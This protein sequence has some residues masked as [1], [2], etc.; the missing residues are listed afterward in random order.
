MAEQHLEK[1]SSEDNDCNN[2]N[3]C[4]W[5]HQEDESERMQY[6]DNFENY[7]QNDSEENNYY[8]KDQVFN[9]AEEDNNDYRLKDPDNY[10]TEDE[11]VEDEEQHASKDDYNNNWDNYFDD[12]IQI[13]PK[14]PRKSSR[15]TS[16]RDYDPKQDIF[17]P[18]IKKKLFDVNSSKNVSPPPRGRMNLRSSGVI[19]D[20]EVL[21]LPTT[22]RRSLPQTQ[23]EKWLLAND[24]NTLPHQSIIHIAQLDRSTYKLDGQRDLEN[25]NLVNNQKI[26]H[27]QEFPEPVMCEECNGNTAEV[28]CKQ[29]N[30]SYCK[31]CSDTKV[32]AHLPVGGANKNK[33]SLNYQED[34][35]I[36]TENEKYVCQEIWSRI[37]P[38]RSI[39]SNR[40]LWECQNQNPSNKT[41]INQNKEANEFWSNLLYSNNT[42]ELD[43]L[44]EYRE[45]ISLA[46]QIQ[47]KIEISKREYNFLELKKGKDSLT[48]ISDKIKE[49]QIVPKSW[50]DQ[51]G[52]YN[53]N[54]EFLP[55]L[56]HHSTLVESDYDKGPN[57][58]V[59]AKHCSYNQKLWPARVI[60]PDT[61]CPGE[62]KFCYIKFFED[63]GKTIKVPKTSVA[64]YYNFSNEI[65][66]RNYD[67]LDKVSS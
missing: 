46:I 40:M 20:I 3:F 25:Y 41:S 62:E 9:L 8:F 66:G 28:H 35:N 50:Q 54:S 18:L 27:R 43:E 63:D 5:K 33:I 19:E 52:N 17:S 36:L 15:K 30:K 59:W 56:I 10:L 47:G 16:R 58:L 37:C 11:I 14:A 45:N 65:D 64:Q 44:I 24:P 42:K 49:M 34:K 67:K 57:D 60:S 32:A 55:A 7:I 61:T 2:E 51:L 29:C 1:N 12:Q 39:F 26:R 53:Y 4:F 22:C 6:S 21:L 48:G 38:H 13:T 31:N 23:E